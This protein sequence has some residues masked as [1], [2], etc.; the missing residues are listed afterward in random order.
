MPLR[1]EGCQPSLD[2]PLYPNCYEDV[3]HLVPRR[4][5]AIARRSAMP[6]TYRKVVRDY[7]AH[8]MNHLVGCRWIHATQLDPQTPDQ[9]PPLEEMQLF[10]TQN[11]G[12]I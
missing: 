7:I 2:C 11:Q 1:G 4:L 12:E 8:P 6:E 3:H 5:G 9:L 10:L